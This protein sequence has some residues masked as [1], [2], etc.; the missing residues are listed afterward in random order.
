MAFAIMER[1]KTLERNVT[2]LGVFAFLAGTIGGSVE[3][4]PQRW[5][6]NTSIVGS[7]QNSGANPTIPPMV[8]HPVSD[9]SKA[10]GRFMVRVE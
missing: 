4:A 10:R 1:H 7:I 6:D 8:T 3:I 9:I 5:I 2:L